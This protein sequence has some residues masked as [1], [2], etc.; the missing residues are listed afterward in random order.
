MP[1]IFTRKF[2]VRWSE[3]DTNGQV[4]PADYLRYLVETAFDWWD[5]SVKLGADDIE[6]LGLFWVVRET[7]L[8]FV[9]PLR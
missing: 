2:R 8:N 4:S 3:I 6:A 5:A 1:K 7:E 9:Q